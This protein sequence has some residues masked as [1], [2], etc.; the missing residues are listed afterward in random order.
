MTAR[1]AV[2]AEGIRLVYPAARLP[3]HGRLMP[4][5]LAEDGEGRVAERPGADIIFGPYERLPQG[6]YR[7]AFRMRLARALTGP[8]ATVGIT[9]ARGRAPLLVQEVAAEALTTGA[10]RE[11]TVELALLPPRRISSGGSE[12]SSRGRPWSIG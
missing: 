4:D 6:R 1:P 7:I 12:P 11:V 10:Y 5:H 3:G 9:A 2:P 8:V